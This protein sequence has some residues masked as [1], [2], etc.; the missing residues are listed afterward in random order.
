MNREWV[1]MV[2]QCL[3]ITSD[4]IHQAR[5][6]TMYN[7]YDKRMIGEMVVVL[8]QPSSV[9]RRMRRKKEEKDLDSGVEASRAGRPIRT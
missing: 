2:N 9:W 7:E 8:T 1:Q 6:S 5:V 4:I 3:C